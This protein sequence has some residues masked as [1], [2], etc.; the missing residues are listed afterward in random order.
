MIW[1]ADPIVFTKLRYLE[2]FR[3]SY[4]WMS[5]KILESHSRIGLLYCSLYH[6]L[7]FFLFERPRK[8]FAYES[9]IEELYYDRS[10]VPMEKPLKNKKIEA[11][12]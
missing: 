1:V 4:I 5:A 6:C 11:M 8:R 12:I 2:P 9:P 10:V 7:S 3:Q